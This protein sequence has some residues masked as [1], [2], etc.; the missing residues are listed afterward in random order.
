MNLWGGL[1]LAGVP[2]RAPLR[3]PLRGPL[4]VPLRGPLRVPLRGPLRGCYRGLGFWVQG[5]GFWG[6]GFGVVRF[7]VRGS[8]LLGFR[9]WELASMAREMAAG[10][11]LGMSRLH[12]VP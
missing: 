11:G 6:L 10:Y 1:G 8:G 3:V 4:R 5:L 2:L 9:V 7:R 12:R